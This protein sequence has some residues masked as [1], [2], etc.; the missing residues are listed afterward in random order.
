MPLSRDRPGAVRAALTTLTML[1]LMFGVDLGLMSGSAQ[2]ATPVGPRRAAT[3]AAP[4][5]APDTAPAWRASVLSGSASIACAPGTTD[6]G[7]H[8]GYHSSARIPVRL[9]AVNNLP[10]T[11]PESNPTSSFYIRNGKVGA[12]RHA[13]VNSRVSRAVQTMVRDMKAAGLS[14]TTF[15]T[16]RSMARQQVLCADDV[17]CRGRNY[18]YLARPGTSNHQMGLAIDFTMPRT[19]SRT[20]RCAAPASEPGNPVW[21]WLS[22]HAGHYGFKQYSAEPWHWEATAAGGC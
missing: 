6:L 7:V 14:P 2:A 19:T 1:C 10:S 5:A 15:S 8:D 22:T 3:D 11:A 20:A 4:D 17:R 9:C 18:R 16:F 12:N 21:R 13:I